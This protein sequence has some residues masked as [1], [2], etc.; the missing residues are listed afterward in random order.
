MNKE[1]IF[2]Y[3]NWQDHRNPAPKHP[4]DSNDMIAAKDKMVDFVLYT[5]NPIISMGIYN[6]H[7][8][9]SFKENGKRYWISND[10]RFV[11]EESDF[12]MGEYCWI[13]TLNQYVD[14]LKDNK[15]LEARGLPPKEHRD[16]YWPKTKE[17]LK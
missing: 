3:M 8:Q 17:V 15:E 6:A 4:L 10:N 5:T 14:W 12:P 2:K 16:K 11:S 7:I 1:L 13:L 9:A